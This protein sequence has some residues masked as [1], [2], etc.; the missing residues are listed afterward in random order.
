MAFLAGKI[1]GPYSYEVTHLYMPDQKTTRSTFSFTNR[2]RLEATVWAGKQDAIFLG[3]AHSHTIYKELNH[4]GSTLS[5][6]DAELQETEH[7][8]LML[9][10][11]FF[12]E[13]LAMACWREGFAAPLNLYR[14][15]GRRLVELLDLIL[16]P[17]RHS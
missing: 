9:V 6:V 15:A 7:L 2:D 4:Y 12:P 14:K 5:I 16:V 11:C 13:G 10:L 8:T 17:G 3:V 1:I